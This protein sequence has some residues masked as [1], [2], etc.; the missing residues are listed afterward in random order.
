MTRFRRRSPAF[1]IAATVM[2]TAFPVHTQDAAPVDAGSPDAPAS[3]GPW[4]AEEF[5]TLPGEVCLYTPPTSTPATKLV[6]FLHGV[7][8]AGTDWQYNQQRAAAR[9]ARQNGFVVLMPRGRMGAG[10]QKFFDHWNWPTS[11]A[12]QKLHEQ[13][14]LEGW[15]RAREIVEQRRERPFEKLY[16]I[17]FSA[18]AYYAVSLALGNRFTADG[19][20]A[21]A[22][23]GAAKDSARRLAAVRRR[24]PIYVGWGLKDKARRDPEKLARV[25]RTAGWPHK[26]SARRGVGHAMTDSMVADAM[27]FFEAKRRN[28]R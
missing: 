28:R 17:G 10:S 13:E 16:V 4:C 21:F 20:A 3:F 11:F 24:A 1:S 15:R 18:G 12:G 26:S 5:E 22:G 6:I 9:A 8:K 14:V 25:L 2:L 23:G 19:F 27:S 7:V